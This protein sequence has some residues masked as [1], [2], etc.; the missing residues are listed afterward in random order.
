[1]KYLRKFNESEDI[2]DFESEFGPEDDDQQEYDMCLW[3]K[4]R[5]KA[6]DIY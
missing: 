3:V 5:S 6:E 2:E 4:E 1:M